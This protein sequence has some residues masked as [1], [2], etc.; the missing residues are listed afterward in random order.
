MNMP[1]EAPP[2]RSNARDVNKE[3]LA[4]C[5]I[6]GKNRNKYTLQKSSIFLSKRGGRI[7]ASCEE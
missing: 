6:Y 1:C 3:K 7:P 5:I 4:E 2:A